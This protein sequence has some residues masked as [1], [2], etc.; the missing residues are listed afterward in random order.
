[1]RLLDRGLCKSRWG[2]S[3]VLLLGILSISTTS[4]AQVDPVFSITP[5]PAS[6]VC[7]GTS[8]SFD[9]SS[10]NDP[11]PTGSISILDGASTVATV[12][13]VNGAATVS[14][15]TLG[16]GSHTLS[17]SYTGDVNYNPY[18][19]STTYPFTVTASCINGY[20]GGGSEIPTIRPGYYG[21]D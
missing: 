6:P 12:A 11:L 8:I 13:L 16:P 4:F 14:V 3:F 17:I 20:T 15:S 7:Q 5:S 18:T 19:S 1:M 10:T 2:Y 21:R 9:V